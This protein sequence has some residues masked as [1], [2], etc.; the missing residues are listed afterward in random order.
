MEARHRLV[1]DDACGFCRWSAARI[2]RW[3]RRGRL[4]PLALSDPSIPALLPHRTPEERAAS[5]HL[6]APDGTARSAGAA[7]APLLR[8]LP[9]GWLVAWLPAATPR[10]TERLYRWVARH[11]ATFGA[12]LGENRCEVVPG[13]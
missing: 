3:D 11:R 4:A 7:V 6:V 8:L 9:G 2:L 13:R 1:Y 12:W 10:T 5:W